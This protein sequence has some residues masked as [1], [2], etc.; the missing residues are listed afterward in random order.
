MY[1]Y[2]ILRYED[3]TYHTTFILYKKY[4]T[5]FA[6]GVNLIHLHF[7]KENR[8]IMGSSDPTII[9]QEEKNTAINKKNWRV[10]RLYDPI[11]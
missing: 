2:C 8:K 9:K 11:L 4:I 6:V 5:A 10:S 3:L 7:L 1:I